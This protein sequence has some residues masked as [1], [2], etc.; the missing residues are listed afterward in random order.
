MPFFRQRN[1][2]LGEESQAVDMHGEFACAGAKKI[3]FHANDVAKIEQF[4]KLEVTLSYRV[5]SHI[6]LQPG[7]AACQVRESGFPVGPDGHHSSRTRTWTFSASSCSDG[8]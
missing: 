7:A 5:A 4:V 2:A 3:A 1:Q 8:L 6:D